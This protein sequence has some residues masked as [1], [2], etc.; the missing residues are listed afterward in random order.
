MA[1]AQRQSKLIWFAVHYVLVVERVKRR[2]RG[3]HYLAYENVLLVRART[4]AAVGLIR[5]GGQFDYAANLS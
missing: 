5:S 3:P 2:K 1:R 4:S